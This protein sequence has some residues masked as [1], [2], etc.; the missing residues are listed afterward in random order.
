MFI[1]MRFVDGPTLADM[2]MQQALSGRETLRILTAIASALDAAHESG[3]VHRDVKP[4]NILH[5]RRRPSLPRR[6][7]HHEGRGELRADQSGDFVGSVSYVSPEQIDGRDVTRAE[8]HLLAH[9]RPVSLPDRDAA[10]RPRHRGGAHARA[11]L[12]AAADDQRPGHR[13]AARRSTRSSRAGWRSPRTI[14]SRAASQLIDACR[15]ALADA[16]LDRCPALVPGVASGSAGA[17][18]QYDP[19]ARDGAAPA[20][21]LAD[22][23][24]R[25]GVRA[26]PAPP[27]A[28]LD[29]ALAPA[30]GATAAD[31]R[32][33]APAPAPAPCATA[34]RGPGHA[35]GRS[36]AARARSSPGSSPLVGAPLLGYALG[37]RDEPSGPSIARSQ[38]LQVSYAPPWEPSGATIPGLGVDG[39]V[40]LRQSD[41]TVLVAGRLRD[42]APGFDPAPASLRDKAAREP[43]A[44][45][46]SVSATATAIRYAV[47]LRAGGSLWMVAFPDTKGWTTVACT[48]TTGRP[49]AR[50]RQRRRDDAVAH[51]DA[52][53]ARC[54][55]A[56]VGRAGPRDP[57]AQPRRA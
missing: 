11:P 47:P 12:R 15:D 14:A 32:R 3:L 42:P 37:D 5:D 55:Q 4:H 1:A 39:A 20:A 28:V 33:E 27:I 48:A 10:L 19:W 22:R 56:R 52:D 21:A 45:S 34:L 26:A 57:Q 9:R 38:S 53:R 24:P 54:R 41:G 31:R 2:V 25:P 8:R 35:V 6:L 30:G 50:L 16:A 13:R 18:P 51:G 40:G 7:R 46:A 49:D 17:A 43:A 23:R 29:P 44:P 36:A